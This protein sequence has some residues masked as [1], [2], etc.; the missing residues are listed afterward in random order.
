MEVSRGKL[1]SRSPAEHHHFI[2]SCRP[3]LLLIAIMM[4]TL[5]Y[6]VD[7]YSCPSNAAPTYFLIG[8]SLAINGQDIQPFGSAISGCGSVP[9][10][11]P[12]YCASLCAARSG[13]QGFTTMSTN[14]QCILKTSISSLWSKS[15]LQLLLHCLQGLPARDFQLYWRSSLMSALSCRN[16]Q[17]H[18][19][20]HELKH[21]SSLLSCDI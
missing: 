3:S 19:R 14:S 12:A 18:Q 7:A 15:N 2:F 17:L 8:L 13:C 1:R 11:C 6:Q 20:S 10:E 16:L 5:Y 4:A 9:A 21:L